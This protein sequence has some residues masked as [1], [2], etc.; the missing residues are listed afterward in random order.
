MYVVYLNHHFREFC[1]LHQKSRWI[2]NSNLN[3]GKGEAAGWGLYLT[4][5]PIDRSTYILT[6]SHERKGVWRNG[7][8]IVHGESGNARRETCPDSTS[9]PTNP[10]GSGLPALTVV[11]NQR[12]VTSHLSHGTILVLAAAVLSK[13]LVYYYHIRHHTPEISNHFKEY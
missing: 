2:T 9:P 8:T 11:R 3:G 12:P 4:I 5:L 1:C 7:R 10:T 13:T 6:V